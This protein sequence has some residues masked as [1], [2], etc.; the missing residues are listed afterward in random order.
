MLRKLSLLSL[1]VISPA[2][3]APDQA[4]RFSLV[5]EAP[6]GPRK[7]G[8][9]EKLAPNSQCRL[10]VQALKKECVVVVTAFSG[11]SMQAAGY[12]KPRVMNLKP[13]QQSSAP[14]AFQPGQPSGKIYITVL[15]PGSFPQFVDQAQHFDQTGPRQQVFN[16]NADWHGAQSKLG[17]SGPLPPELGGVS[18]TS[19]QTGHP[20]PASAEGAGHPKEAPA[21]MRKI[22]ADSK[23]MSTFD[24]TR[25]ADWVTWQTGLPGVH[26]YKIKLTR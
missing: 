22:E 12:F 4:A 26:V 14:I 19:A 5:V 11:N 7:L 8:A 23:I 16:S 18:S 24:W 10:Y 9:N 25:G 13:G 15:A 17:H 1:L 6:T 3:A 21:A 2:L 20:A